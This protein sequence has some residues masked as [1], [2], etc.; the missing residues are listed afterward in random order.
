[1]VTVHQSRREDAVA[2]SPALHIQNV[3]VLGPAGCLV[4]ALGQG[5]SS[6]VV[7]GRHALPK[8]LG[9]TVVSALPSWRLDLHIII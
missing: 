8:R 3:Y 6:Y 1:M 2:R 7:T 5:F 9:D 4:D